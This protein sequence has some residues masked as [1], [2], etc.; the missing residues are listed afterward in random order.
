MFE[1]FTQIPPAILAFAFGVALFAGFVKGAVGFALPMIMISGLGSQLSPELALAALIV[2]TVAANLWQALRDGVAAALGTTRKYWLYMLIVLV[3][4]AGS[5]Q[6]VRV[7]PSWVFFLLLGLPI[8][9]FALV[10]IVGWKLHIRP[11]HRTRA[12]LGIGAVAGFTGG[13]SGVWGPPTVAYLT[14]I[15][16][17]KGESMRMQGVVYAAG[18]IVLLASHLRSGVLNAQTLPLSFAMLVPVVLGM[19]AGYSVHDRLDAVKFR[20]AM[21]VVLVVAGL[22][23]IRRGVMGL[24]F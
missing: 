15:D 11:E 6:L 17:P 20:R 4:I 5:A 23:L 19:V 14:A 3:F 18:S 16:A 10:Q 9:G 12:E 7:I 8:T 24:L 21:L 22:N 1:V 13:L 2:P